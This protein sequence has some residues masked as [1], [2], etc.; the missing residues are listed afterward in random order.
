[1]TAD[2]TP[3]RETIVSVLFEARRLLTELG[4]TRFATARDANGVACKLNSDLAAQFDLAG[5][6]TRACGAVDPE[7]KEFYFK[8]FE[9]ACAD[10][11]RRNRLWTDTYTRWNDR[12]ALSSDDVIQLIETIIE[13][14]K[15]A[16]L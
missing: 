12:A 7:H 10:A 13:A 5:A 6:L 11:L 16:P 14:I 4:W 9:L 2:M 3:A 8:F 1:M 15:A